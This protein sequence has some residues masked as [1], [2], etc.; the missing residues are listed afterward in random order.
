VEISGGLHAGDQVIV[1]E[2][3]EFRNRPEI[4]IRY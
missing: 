2:T 1:S 4:D 3:S